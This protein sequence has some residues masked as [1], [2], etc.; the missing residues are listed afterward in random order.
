MANAR[1]ASVL[2]LAAAFMAGYATEA[3]SQP[4]KATQDIVGASKVTKVQLEG[5][6]VAIKGNELVATMVPGGGLRLFAFRPGKTATIDGKVMPLAQVP[7]GTRLAADVYTIETPVLQRTVTTLEGTVWHASP[8]T[9]ILTLRNGEN[10]Q[11]EVPPG[12]K[13]E[14]NGQMKEAMELK[15]GLEVHATKVVESPRVE[16]RQESVVTGTSK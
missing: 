13:F 14:V 4:A 7:V 2:L 12:L 3:A 16:I 11:Y 8:T 10:R 9:V 5:K 1:R 15:P 6:V